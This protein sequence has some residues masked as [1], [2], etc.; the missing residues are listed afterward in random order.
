MKGI[1]LAGGAGTRLNPL[2]SVV[3]KQLLPVYDKP[4]IYYPLSTLISLGINE[5]LIISSPSQINDFKSL[6]GNGRRLGIDLSYE[7]QSEPNGIAEALIIGEFF[8]Q[9]DSCALILGDNIFISDK[10][11]SSEVVNF[12]KGARIF[13]ISVKDPERYGVIKLLNNIPVEIV[14]KP[15]EFISNN[16]VTGLYFYD[17]QAT[18]LCKKLKPSNRNELEITDLNKVYL[19]NE[20]LSVSSLGESEAWMDAG[21]FE[22]LLDAGNYIAALQKR[23]GRLVGSPELASYNQGFLNK[24]D[25]LEL[26]KNAPN[27]SYYQLLKSSIT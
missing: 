11:V 4:L 3:S 14:E 5:I 26:I 10:I 19:K 23:L 15:K 21:T 27:N 22:S 25:L 12:K 13:T 1:I 9:E 24:S 17:N 16:A 8:L 20:M 18:S 6:L 7:V 2:T